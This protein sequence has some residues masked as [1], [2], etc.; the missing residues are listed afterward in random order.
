VAPFSHHTLDVT[1]LFSDNQSTI[2]LTKDYQYHAHTKH[3]NIWFHFIHWII[4]EG[5][6]STHFL[7]YHQ[8]GSG[9]PH[10]GSPFTKSQTFHSQVGS[11]I[12]LRGSI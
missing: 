1:T 8:Y 5:F 7:S 9:C 4:K 11:H 6:P 10:K 2:M 3:I 12:G